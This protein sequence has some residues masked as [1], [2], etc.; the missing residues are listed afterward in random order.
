MVRC[1]RKSCKPIFIMFTLSIVIWP[2]DGSNT[3]NN[4][5]VN[6]D[7]PAPVRP[8]MPTCKKYCTLVVNTIIYKAS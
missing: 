2:E 5:K 8:T 3:R 7:L 1:D 4:A 6:E